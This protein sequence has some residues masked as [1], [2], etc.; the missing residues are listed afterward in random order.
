[1]IIDTHCHLDDDSYDGDFSEVLDRA[2]ANGVSKIIIPGADI[3][4]LQKARN[5]AHANENIYFAVG[6]HPYHCNDFDL[7]ILETFANDEKCVAV[8]ECGL[9]YYRLKSDF[10]SDEQRAEH[11][12]Q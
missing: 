8:G 1:M 2:K 6:V 4:D 3:N 9:D 7:S 5:L 11:K 12:R 10:D